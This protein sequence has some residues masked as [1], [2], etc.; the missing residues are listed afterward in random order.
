MD[1][2]VALF[3][4]DVIKFRPYFSLKPSLDK[5]DRPT[6][7]RGSHSAFL[8]TITT[9]TTNTTTTATTTA[10]ATPTI[11]VAILWLASTVMGEVGAH[12]KGGGWGVHVPPGQK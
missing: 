1:Y 8:T 6:V 10:T 12:N 4:D 9:T 11:T 3:C 7:T 5:L 2:S